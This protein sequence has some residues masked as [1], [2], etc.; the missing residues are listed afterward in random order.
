MKEAKQEKESQS[1]IP[2][3]MEPKKAPTIGEKRV[4]KIKKIWQIAF[5]CN[6]NE[7]LQA[8]SNAIQITRIAK[9]VNDSESM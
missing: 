8:N 3:E 1:A 4:M 5:F 6:K 7:S 2:V 9:I